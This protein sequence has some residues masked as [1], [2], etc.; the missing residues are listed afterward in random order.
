MDEKEK[1]LLLY[2]ALDKIYAGNEIHEVFDFFDIKKIFINDLY[3]SI[4]NKIQ[5]SLGIDE[6]SIDMGTSVIQIRYEDITN[7]SFWIEG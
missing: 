1:K 6:M 2:N 3:I 5:I 7:F 4:E